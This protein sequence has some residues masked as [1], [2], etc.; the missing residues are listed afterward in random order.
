[1]QVVEWRSVMPVS[2]GDVYSWHTRPGAAER[3]TPPW[4]RVCV[5]ERSGGP[6]SG[7]RLGLVCRSGFAKGR[8]MLEYMGH[9]PG[10]QIGVRL[11][12]GP[13]AAWEHTS[14]FASAAG[15]PAASM[16]VDHVE[17][18]LPGGR[19]VEPLSRRR[20]RREL[21]RV[22]RFRH[23][24]LAADLARHARWSGE[25]RLRVAISGAGGLV[26]SHLV[27]YLAIAGHEVVRLVRRPASAPG[28]VSWDPAAGRLDP[29]DLVGVDAVV[30]LAG[31]SIGALWTGARRR[32]ILESRI[33]ST[34]TLVE[35]M[36]RMETPPKVFISA[37]AVGAYG[38][39]GDAVITEDAE[40]GAGYLADVCRTWEAAAAPAAEL[41]VRVV[42]PRFGIVLSGAGGVLPTLLSMFRAG[43]GARLGSG[44]QWWSWVSLDDLLG[45]LEWLLHDEV[46]TGA[47]N[48]T[49]PG[50]VPNG[51]FTRVL[52]RVLRRPAL[53]TAP[54]PAVELALGGVAAEMLMASQ[55]V[56]P[57][58]LRSRGFQFGFPHLESA[59]RFELGR[60]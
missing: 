5:V 23:A 48:V 18:E 37:S 49:S 38:S 25:P 53:L 15:D 60:A 3:L 26:G 35:A 43:A 55:R 42:T 7:G 12:E 11:L 9:E 27:A 51:D 22:F 54:A 52:G 56:L 20:G 21:E 2:A 44:D 28:E 31:A 59:L 46:V 30:N 41:G 33:Q 14:R 10:R 29:A 16:L 17:Y 36:A 39:R 57:V 40:F 1:M 24:R 58:A 19:R 13:L 32:A 6:E 45:A 47:V 34:G 4:W 50:P 8:W